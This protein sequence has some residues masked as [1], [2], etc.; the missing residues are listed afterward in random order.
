[1]QLLSILLNSQSSYWYKDRG[2]MLFFKD[3]H[4]VTYKGKC[5]FL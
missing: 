3:S 1:M 2:K 4:L 5:Q